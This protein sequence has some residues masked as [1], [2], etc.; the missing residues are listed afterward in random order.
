MSGSVTGDDYLAIDANLG[1]GTS[2]PLTFTE[3]KEEMVARHAAMFGEEYLVKL[4]AVE[5]T[6]FTVVPEPSVLGLVG[7]AA[8]GIVFQ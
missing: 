6:G 7:V 4:A 3:M 8:L 1:K 2:N 5:A